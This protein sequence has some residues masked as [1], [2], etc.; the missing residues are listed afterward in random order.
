LRIISV[1][2]LPGFFSLVLHHAF[3]EIDFLSGLVS[4]FCG[5]SSIPR[6]FFRGLPICLDLGTISFQWSLPC[7]KR[8]DVLEINKITILKSSTCSVARNLVGGGLIF[9]LGHWRPS[10][11]S[12]FIPN[13]TG[14]FSSGCFLTFSEQVLSLGV[15]GL[16]V[17]LRPPDFFLMPA[18]GLANEEFFA[19]AFSFAGSPAVAEIIL[20]HH[21]P[22][23]FA[24]LV[25][26]LSAQ[27]LPLRARIPSSL[28]SN[29]C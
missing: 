14:V 21:P 4:L 6:F 19:A 23:F 12:V 20:A 29:C 1:L 2:E 8:V 16:R 5:S 17:G 22:P 11:P 7:S 10:C 26:C 28:R 18:L 27:I 15:L 24:A 25:P 9:P 3:F 13:R